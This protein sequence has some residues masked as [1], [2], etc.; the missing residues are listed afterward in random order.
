MDARRG[1]LA[2]GN[3]LQGR[4]LTAGQSKTVL[5]ALEQAQSEGLS[6]RQARARARQ[7]CEADN[8]KMDWSAIFDK[9]GP[10][11]QLIMQLLAFFK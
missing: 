10:I 7:I 9:I 2:A 6:G 8:P 4:G 5:A 3:M 1:R 11:F